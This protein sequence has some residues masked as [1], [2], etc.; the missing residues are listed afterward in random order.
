MRRLL[1]ILL[2]L[3]AFNTTVNAQDAG[4]EAYSRL[5]FGIEWG[6]VASFFSGY[7]YN[8]FAQEGFRVDEK[9][10]SLRYTSNADMYV[11]LGWNID[12]YWNLSLCL[13]YAGVS[14]LHNVIPVS[15]RGT[16]YFGNDPMSDRWFAFLDLGS[17]FGAKRPVQE[18]L[19]G[20]AGGGYRLSLSRDTKLDFLF[21]VRTTCTHPTIHQDGYIISKDRINRNNA[22]VSAFSVG[23][24]IVF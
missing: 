8:Y 20:K 22:W 19:A 16:R 7:H 18:I 17:G 13:G 6:Y 2:I 10:N 11:T 5:T 15:L 9:G 23:M 14:D 1:S 12:R 21:S 24:A 4:R 3:C